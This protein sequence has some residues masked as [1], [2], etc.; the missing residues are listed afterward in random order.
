MTNVGFQ[1]YSLHDVQD[2]IPAMI[3][4]VGKTSFDGVELAGLGDGKTA[5]IATAC[6]ETGLSLAAA[7]VG[8]DDIEA[9]PDAVAAT[10]SDLGCTDLVVPWLD[11]DVFETRAAIETA[12]ER[13]TTA[14]TDLA[15]HG[16]DLHYH[17]H[18]HEFTRVDDR[19]GLDVLLDAADGVGLELDLGWVGAAGH[20]PLPF[21]ESRA[22]R[23]DFVHLKDY[24][25]ATG[26]TVE[27]GSGDLDIA[28]TVDLVRDHDVEWLIYEA[29]GRPD[30]Y[31]TLDHADEIVDAYW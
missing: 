12:G 15:P 27:V 21:L 13:L 22:D 26:E 28:A 9:D 8:L 2:P 24:D 20:D 14:A 31:E 4:R 16:I 11:P 29:E 17:N 23:V 6:D 7:H 3:E 10:Y 5:D 18:G 25:G 30:S 19:F 1:L